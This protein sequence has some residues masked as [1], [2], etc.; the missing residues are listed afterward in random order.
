MTVKADSG[1]SWVQ[2]H[3]KAYLESGGRDGHIMDFTALGGRADQ[4]TLL[5]RTVGRRSG[6][7]KLAPLI[8]EKV[9]EEY[10]I[11][12]SKG[13]APDHPGWYHNL[14][15]APEVRFQVG[16]DIF[17]GTCRE[18]DGEERQRVWARMVEAY[19]PYADYQAKTSRRIPVILLKPLGPAPAL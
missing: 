13:G 3:I 7:A 5:L 15:A 4:K 12:A 10:A 17:R 14:G 19:A 6:T 2:D 8:Y 9:G 16:T 11:I 18:A 1:R